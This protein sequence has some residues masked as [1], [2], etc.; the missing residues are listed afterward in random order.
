MDR[1]NSSAA[2]STARRSRS[3]RH[4]AIIQA[5]SVDVDSF[6]QSLHMA[7]C[8]SI[9]I[10]LVFYVLTVMPVPI[11]ELVDSLEVF[12]G[13]AMYTQAVLRRS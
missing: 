7:G 4:K 5:R 12:S 1:M 13:M 8:P 10:K 3:P 6:L 9:L 2:G 11:E